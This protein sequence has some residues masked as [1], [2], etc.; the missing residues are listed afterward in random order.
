MIQKTS[1]WMK[2]SVAFVGQSLPWR[3][4]SR[5]LVGLL[6]V[7]CGVYAALPSGHDTRAVLHPSQEVIVEAEANFL[8]SRIEAALAFSP[9]WTDE[10]DRDSYVASLKKWHERNEILACRFGVPEIAQNETIEAATRVAIPCESLTRRNRTTGEVVV[11]QARGVPHAEI[12]EKRDS[13]TGPRWYV[14]DDSPDR[15]EVMKSGWLSLPRK[16]VA[17]LPAIVLRKAVVVQA[18]LEGKVVSE[19]VIFAD[20]PNSR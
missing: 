8:M 2:T 1:K 17:D 7:V 18:I 20:D 3:R 9:K 16:K 4:T 14:L 5:G 15:G 12:L 19:R 13:P 11:N 10:K 6:V